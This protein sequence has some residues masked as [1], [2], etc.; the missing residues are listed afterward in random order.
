MKGNVASRSFVLL[1][2][3]LSVP[4]LLQTTYSERF[5]VDGSFCVSFLQNTFPKVG[6][7]VKVA[8]SCPTL[9]DP[10]DYRVHEIL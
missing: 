7:R 10:M 8:Q 2:D 5:W 1:L 6:S 4:P 3:I 9:Y